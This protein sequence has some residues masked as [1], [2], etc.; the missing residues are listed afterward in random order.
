MYALG[1]TDYGIFSV[2]VDH[3]VAVLA[4]M[5]FLKITAFRQGKKKSH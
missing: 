5:A 1:I 4:L 2:S 3:Q